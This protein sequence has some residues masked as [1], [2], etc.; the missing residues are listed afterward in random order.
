MIKDVVLVFEI[1][2]DSHW[3]K[4]VVQL[5]LALARNTGGEASIVVRPNDMQHELAKH[6]RLHYYG[7]SSNDDFSAD[8]SR[9]KTN[10]IWY[11]SACN[12]AAKIGEILILYP[13]FGNPIL[14]AIVFKLKRW[15]KLKKASVIIKSDGILMYLVNKVSIK[16]KLLE[17]LKFPFIDQ[18]ICEDE[19]I[20]SKIQMNHPRLVKKIVYI[21]NCP[22][23]IYHSQTI[24]NYASRPNNF[25]FVGRI[26]DREKGADI[27][28]DT[29]LKIN[30]KLP[31][32][33]LYMVGTCSDDFKNEWIARLSS[34]NSSDSVAWIQGIPPKEL[35]NFY[36]NSKVVIC[37]S[38]KEGAPIIIS[39]SALSGCSFIG[40]A[41]G[42]IPNILNGLPGLVNEASELAETMLLFAN[43]P[44]LAEK[45]A[46]ELFQRVKLRNWDEQVR[47]IKLEA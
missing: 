4:D 17:V 27:L 6:I 18:I 20:Y 31:D 40:T 14:G 15:L 37:S 35:I 26:S 41:V 30:K 43:N 29:W 25:L 47:K 33:K 36:N 32:W 38:R 2:T 21:P 24:K 16:L 28:L 7:S 34:E 45:Q 39:E 44:S 3:M 11:L 10:P 8:F 5:P 42:E 23:G 19:T 22:L 9:V 13:F 1:T 46:K 12:E